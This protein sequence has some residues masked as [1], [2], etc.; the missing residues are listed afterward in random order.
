MRDVARVVSEV[1]YAD[2]AMVG[3]HVDQDEKELWSALA[4]SRGISLS[5]FVREIVRERLM[6]DGF[7]ASSPAARTPKP[8][9]IC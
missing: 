4:A 8:G 7:A 3:V 5:R 9:P 1:R 6:Q 2:R